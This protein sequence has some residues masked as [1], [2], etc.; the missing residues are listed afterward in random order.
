MIIQAE[1][2]CNNGHISKHNYDTARD[3]GRSGLANLIERIDRGEVRHW[4]FSET[5]PLPSQKVREM[6]KCF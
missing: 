2:H 1:V 4:E 5:I 6:I 3:F